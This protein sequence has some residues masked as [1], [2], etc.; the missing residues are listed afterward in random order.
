MPRLDQLLSAVVTR[1]A[2]ALQVADADV[3][4]LH[5]SGVAREADHALHVEASAGRVRV[6]S[7]LAISRLAST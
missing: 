3:A 7:E 1:G 6:S 5:I 2:T 4:R